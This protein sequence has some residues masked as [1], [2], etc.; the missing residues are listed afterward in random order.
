LRKQIKKDE[1]GRG[2]AGG[3]NKK[4][5]NAHSI[6]MRKPEGRSRREKYIKMNFK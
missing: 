6:L 5:R 2:Q 4:R 1:T 3:K